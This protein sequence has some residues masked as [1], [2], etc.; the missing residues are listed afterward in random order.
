MVTGMLPYILTVTSDEYYCSLSQSVGYRQDALPTSTHGMTTFESL[1]GAFEEGEDLEQDDDTKSADGDDQFPNFITP[2]TAEILIRAR[3]SLKLLRA[4]QPDHPLLRKEVQSH[5]KISWYWTPIE[6]ESAWHGRPE[7]VAVHNEGV[8]LDIVDPLTVSNSDGI[9]QQFKIFDLEP[10]SL[11]TSL[12][13]IEAHESPLQKFLDAFPETL[14]TLT[15]TL[16]HLTELTLS[17]LIDHC[18]SVSSSLLSLILSPSSQL[19]IR[20]HLVLLQSYMLLTSPSFTLR[21]QSA[22]FSDSDDWN[23]EGSSARA[24]AKQ[25]QT[26]PKSTSTNDSSSATWAVGLGLGLSERDSWPPGGADLSYYLRT[27]IVD[28]LESSERSRLQGSPDT[29]QR[30]VKE[31]QALIFAEAEFRLGFAIRDLPMG[32]GREKWLNPCCELP[33]PMLPIYSDNIATSH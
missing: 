31:G 16:S 14:P 30:E 2:E 17:P 10:G 12:F 24:L 22:L 25:S 6:V 19:N 33:Q 4:A 32:S 21:L 8:Q 1:D 11:P 15:P 27:V 5:K 9:L 23:F 18:A 13:A 3:K 26:R 28:S 20:S 7:V 29:G